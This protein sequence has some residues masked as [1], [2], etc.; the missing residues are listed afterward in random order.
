LNTERSRTLAGDTLALGQEAS[1]VTNINFVD[2]I[3]VDILGTAGL[4]CCLHGRHTRRQVE[5]ALNQIWRLPF[6]MAASHDL[7]ERGFSRTRYGFTALTL[8]PRRSYWLIG[9]S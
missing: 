8:P 5:D 6:R 9:V 4:P 1:Q 3:R 2:N 7:F